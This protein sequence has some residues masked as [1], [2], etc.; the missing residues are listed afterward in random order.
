MSKS[1]AHTCTHSPGPDLD[2]KAFFSDQT[3]KGIMPQTLSPNFLIPR[4]SRSGCHTYILVILDIS[5]YW[6]IVKSG[7]Q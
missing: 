5:Q 3:M 2:F 4:F 7:S 1:S 6:V